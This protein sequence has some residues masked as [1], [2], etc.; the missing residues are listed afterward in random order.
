MNSYARIFEIKEKHS[1]FVSQVIQDRWN[2]SEKKAL[3]LVDGYL[4]N[5]NNSACFVAEHNGL[6]IG[7]GTFHVNN[8]VKIDL[9]PWCIGLWVK[10]KHRGHG[11]GYKISL[12]RFSLAR[13]LGYEKIY[14]DTVNAEEYHKNLDGKI[15][16]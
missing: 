5:T 14:L 9:H 6:P 7:M 8:D 12:K 3:Q 2:I 13:K 11:I 10:P 15:Q 16:D 4:S 1:E